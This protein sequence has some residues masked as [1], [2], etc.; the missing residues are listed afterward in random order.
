MPGLSRSA[1]IAALG[2]PDE[3]HRSPTSLWYRPVDVADRVADLLGR[4]RAGGAGLAGPGTSR[5]PVLPTRTRQPT[6]RETRSASG[7][8]GTMNL[9]P[10]S[11]RRSS[12]QGAAASLGSLEPCFRRGGQRTGGKSAHAPFQVCP[13]FAPQRIR[14]WL[15]SLQV[16]EK[17]GVPN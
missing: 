8:R 12:T 1:P 2:E 3:R 13:E 9:A 6:T 11:R 16:L 14:P 17:A 10:S 5:A 4:E 7:L 15:C